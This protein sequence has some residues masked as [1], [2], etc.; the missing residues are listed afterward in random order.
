MGEKSLRLF[1]FEVNPHADGKSHSEENRSLMSIDE[2]G[3]QVED[4]DAKSDGSICQLEQ[5]KYRCEFCHREFI[6]SQALGGHQNAHSK[7]RLK[8]KRMLLQIKKAKLYP[9]PKESSTESLSLAS[10]LQ[11]KS[12]SRYK[13]CSPVWLVGLMFQFLVIN[14]YVWLKQMKGR[15]VIDSDNVDH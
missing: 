5:K 14:Y 2:A 7:E 3:F 12:K 4:T 11:I 13:S 1:G 9:Q 6:N 8:K 15:L 10:T